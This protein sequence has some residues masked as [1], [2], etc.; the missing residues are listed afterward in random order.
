MDYGAAKDLK[1]VAAAVML[2]ATVVEA[3]PSEQ[4]EAAGHVKICP[5]S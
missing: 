2:Q 4:V 5:G 3:V 1:G